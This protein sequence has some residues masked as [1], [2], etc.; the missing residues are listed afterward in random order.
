MNQLDWTSWQMIKN[1]MWKSKIA[2][3]TS[4]NILWWINDE[5]ILSWVIKKSHTQSRSLSN[6]FSFV[7]SVF[8]SSS[9]KRLKTIFKLLLSSVHSGLKEQRGTMLQTRHVTDPPKLLN[10]YVC[11]PPTRHLWPFLFHMKKPFDIFII[12]V[13]LSAKPS[14]YLTKSVGILYNYWRCIL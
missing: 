1:E 10:N 8:H 4:L 11:P 13:C 9:V 12:G 3:S 14:P 7:L 5:N 6:W 2:F